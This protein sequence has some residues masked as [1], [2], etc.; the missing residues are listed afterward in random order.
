MATEKN[1]TS[2]EA[3][4]GQQIE[5]FIKAFRTKDVNLMMSLYAPEFV[6]FDIIPPLQ[7]VGI[8]AYRKVWEETFALFKA[9]VHIEIRDQNIIT[10]DDVA[11]SHKFL[12]LQAMRT[13]GQKIDYWERLTFCFR[14]IDGKWLLTHEHVSLPVDLKNGKAA[15]DLKP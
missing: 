2:D 13:N 11:F 7:Y 4:I 14:K 5:S 6:A 12:R 10:G 15:M 1:K 8:D 3:Q 9:P